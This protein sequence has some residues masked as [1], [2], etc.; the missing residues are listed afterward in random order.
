MAIAHSTS[1][2]FLM[3]T[4]SSTT[5]TILSGGKAENVAMIACFDQP[6][7]TGRMATTQ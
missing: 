4:S 2:G 7:R 5:V 3:S 1:I 6:A